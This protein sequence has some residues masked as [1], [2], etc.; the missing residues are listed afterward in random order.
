MA[1]VV[2]MAVLVPGLV[3][4]ETVVSGR[5]PA[6]G[7]EALGLVPVAETAVSGRGREA[8][9]GVLDL[10]LWSKALVNLTFLLT[11]NCLLICLFTI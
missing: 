3:P 8:E 4:V 5:V 2:D 10:E 1:A 6:A 11:F 7:M 9:M